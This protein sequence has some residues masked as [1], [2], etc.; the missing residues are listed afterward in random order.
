MY[1]KIKIMKYGINNYNFDNNNEQKF[2]NCLDDRK[3]ISLGGIKSELKDWILKWYEKKKNPK[4]I[5]NTPPF[6]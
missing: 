5:N 2:N 1:K 6:I 3:P 4:S